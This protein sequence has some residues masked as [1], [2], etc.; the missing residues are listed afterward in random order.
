MPEV[1]IVPTHVRLWKRGCP[2]LWV[3]TLKLEG[4]VC[5]PQTVPRSSTEMWRHDVVLDY[6]A[7]CREQ[8]PSTQFGQVGLEARRVQQRREYLGRRTAARHSTAGRR[9]LRPSG[10]RWGCPD[11]SSS[12]SAASLEAAGGRAPCEGRRSAACPALRRCVSATV[13][14]RHSRTTRATQQ[15]SMHCC[16][17]CNAAVR[18]RQS[19]APRRLAGPSAPVLHDDAVR[20]RRSA[21]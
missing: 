5:L 8:Q 13:A 18:V 17:R 16:T 19:G 3:V 6:I 7:L 12:P 11:P 10:D 4:P 9:H 21:P 20:S 15:V 14:S 2:G 1:V